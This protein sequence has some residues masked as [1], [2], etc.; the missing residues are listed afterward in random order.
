MERRLLV[1]AL[2]CAAAGAFSGCCGVEPRPGD[3]LS[4]GFRSPTQCF[5]TYRNAVAADQLALEYRCLSSDFKRRNELSQLAYREFRD[6]LEGRFPWFGCLAKA[7]IV[8]EQAFPPDRHR[9]VAE[10]KVLFARRRFVVDFVREDF[11]EVFSGEEDLLDESV[12]WADLVREAPQDPESLEVSVP[13]F[14]E[15]GLA[16]VTEVRVGREWKIDGFGEAE[17]EP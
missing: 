8:E 1:A 2:A 17:P 11:Q 4:V 9:I 12:A 16:D 10:V 6:E 3:W 13:T 15:F 7:R 5:H 14:G